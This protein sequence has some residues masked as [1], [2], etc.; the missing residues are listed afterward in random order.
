M[1]D[2]MTVVRGGG[3]NGVAIVVAKV[4]YDA[5]AARNVLADA[6]RVL[7]VAQFGDNY[8][9]QRKAEKAIYDGTPAPTWGFAT[10]VDADRYRFDAFADRVTGTFDEME[11]LLA[12]W[13]EGR[14]QPGQTSALRP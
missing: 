2:K 14:C 4:T 11:E 5:I 10:F 8:I 3:N 1:E 12:P 6:A 9:E 13:R 7:A